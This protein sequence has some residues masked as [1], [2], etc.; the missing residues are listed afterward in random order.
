MDR[1]QEKSSV[2]DQVDIVDFCRACNAASSIDTLVAHTTDIAARRTGIDAVA[3]IVRNKEGTAEV[4]VGARDI[5]GEVARAGIRAYGAH[6]AQSIGHEV[7]GKDEISLREVTR[8]L[9]ASN[10]KI[11]EVARVV[12]SISFGPS[13]SPTGALAFFSHCNSGISREHLRGIET[14]CPIITDAIARIESTNEA[15]DEKDLS[16]NPMV[17][18]VSISHLSVI[19]EIFGADHVERIVGDVVRRIINVLPR[20]SHISRLKTGYIGFIAPV[21]SPA[22][23]GAICRKIEKDCADLEIADS[24]MISVRAIAATTMTIEEAGIHP[25]IPV[26]TVQGEPLF[27]V[28][29][30]EEQ[31]LV[32]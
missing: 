24:I 28:L 32:S 19:G 17:G 14:I 2:I 1:H 5:L 7:I 22:Q 20:G 6:L 30:D 27:P 29:T 4:I 9:P 18:T 16:T 3:L 8:A 13:E 15:V 25:L 23:S 31:A 12:W 10:G 21:V 26:P 11:L